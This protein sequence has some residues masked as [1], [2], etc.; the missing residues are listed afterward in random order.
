MDSREE[1][2][3]VLTERKVV[4]VLS[5]LL[6]RAAW[7]RGLSKS[8]IAKGAASCVGVLLFGCLWGYNVRTVSFD[9]PVRFVDVEVQSGVTAR[10]VGAALREAGLDVSETAF[11]TAMRLFGDAKAIH[12][13]RYRFEEG[14][15]LSDIVNRLSSGVVDMGQVRIPDGVTIWELRKL[16][17]D[18]SDLQDKTSTMS[19]AELLKALG[20][21]E[22]HPEGLFAPDTYK[23]NAGIS[24]LSFLKTAYERQKL[25]LAEE[26][27]K[28]ENN[29]K[30]KS[31]YEALILASIIEKETG[32]HTDRYLVSSVFHNRLKIWMPLQTDPTVIYALGEKY[33]GKIRKRDLSIE[34]PYN[35][36]V[37]YGLP[38]TPIA[39]PTRASIHAALHP[40]KTNY[41]Y[42][43]ARGDG[44][45][46]FSNAL[47][48]HNSA[49]L[50]YQIRK[51]KPKK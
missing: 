33:C 26:W 46:K 40:A 19:A 37:N 44:T 31:P 42:F 17:K 35:T 4:S 43:V 16:V 47:I 29:L 51:R 30:L 7:I 6:D 15:S 9:R 36:Y 39:M 12:T 28:R 20:V 13:G 3:S 34:S 24:D 32:I 18:C 1:K 41:L 22:K 5:Q 25:I 23:F 11:L 50:T 38:P 27:E 21:E 8:T 49:V 14:V 48:E 45:T 10:R 2:T